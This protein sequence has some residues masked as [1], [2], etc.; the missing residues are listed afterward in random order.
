VISARLAAAWGAAG[1]AGAAGPG[2]VGDQVP[3]GLRCLAVRSWRDASSADK[4]WE[5]TARFRGVADKALH[6]PRRIWRRLPVLN[7]P[8]IV[9]GTST[10]GSIEGAGQSYRP[11]LRPMI[12]FMISQVPPKIDRPAL[13]V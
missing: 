8:D 2:Q 9:L 6:Y 12:S 5:A 1:L 4:H 11:R 13:W 3:G 7:L 10:T